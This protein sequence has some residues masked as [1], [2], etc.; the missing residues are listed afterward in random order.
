MNSPR[1]QNARAVAADIVGEWLRTHAFPDRLIGPRAADRAFLVEV[2]Y[3]VVRWWRALMWIQGR[4]TQRR[5]DAAI[6]PHLLVGL[7]QVL[8]MD[9]VPA[10]AAVNE[11]VTAA[12]E[13]VR[14][15]APRHAAA[16]VSFVNAVLKQ[17]AAR[18]G[19]LLAELARRNL[20]TRASHP[21]ALIRRWIA[22]YGQAKAEAICDWD[23]RRPDVVVRVNRRKT[24]ATAYRDQLRA[25]GVD[26][27][28]HPDSPDCLVMPHGAR[29]ACLPGYGDGLFS[30]QDPS[31]LH[32]VELL[33]PRPGQRVLDACAA[34]GGKTV[35]LA[36]R[37][38]DTGELIAA[39]L[40]ADR[41]APLRE[42]VARLGLK[43]VTIVQA[44]AAGPDPMERLTDGRPFDRILLD[45]PCTNTGVL[46][47][48]P[49]ARWR[50]SQARLD[51][52]MRTQE[53]LLRNLTRFVASG[54][55][56]V[57]STCSIEPEENE[58]LVR[59]WLAG[60]REFEEADS[61]LVLP[62]ERRTDGAYAVALRRRPQ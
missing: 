13:A 42:N 48:R 22:H 36:E 60:Q 58:R 20:G 47:R 3:G 1:P 31:T 41:L 43:S 62:G 28:P 23:N 59:R 10:Y 46:A 15:H 44:N 49:D 4:L 51:A 39:D 27:E 32:A 35:L 6:Q 29:V 2:V 18:R 53:A 56:L 45:A 17:S 61:R 9:S 37:L 5:P 11:T 14:A 24:D 38:G 33:D 12:K 7:Y 40:E 25:A 54:G 21:D 50:F 55:L 52:V 34:P 26:A 57:Y 19:D 16:M 30:I 8:M